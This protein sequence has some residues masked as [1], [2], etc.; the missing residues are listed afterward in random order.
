M[1]PPADAQTRERSTS[2]SAQVVTV[3]LNPALDETFD[4]DEIVPERKLTVHHVRRQPGGGGLNVARVAA[5]LGADV[6]ALWSRGG[7]TGQELGE[8]LDE[9]KVPHQPIEI[10]GRTRRNVIAR[11]LGRDQQY[12][13]GLPGAPLSADELRRF[14]DALAQLHPAPAFLVLSGSLPPG[15]P[16]SWYAHAVRHAPTS[17]RVV[18]DTKDR[19]LALAVED[20]GAYLLKPNIDELERLAGHELRGDDAVAE[21][22]LRIVRRGQAELVLV[23]LGRAGAWLVSREGVERIVAPCVRPRSKVGAGDSMVG[24]MVTALAQGRPPSEAARYAVAAG[25]AAVL[26]EGTELCRPADVE[27]L[28]HDMTRATTRVETRA[29]AAAAPPHHQPDAEPA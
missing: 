15:V 29:P 25:S 11:D 4:V 6:L 18:V 26:T 20:G 21:V 24:A 12:R 8:R 16:P 7:A 22:A 14:D 1:T 28:F 10:A 13:F 23:S 2:A 9:E 3:T 19:A 17:T 5:R 27:R